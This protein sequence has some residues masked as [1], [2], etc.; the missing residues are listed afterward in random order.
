[1]NPKDFENSSAGKCIKTLDGYWAFLPDPL[2]PL[3][4]YDSKLIKLLSE[5]DRLLGELSGTGRL[6]PNPYL[7]IAPYIRREAVSSSRIEGTQ[8]SLSD[9]FFY[10]AAEWEEPKVPDV[11]EVR[12]YV[13]AMEYGIKRL[14]ELPVSVRLIS[15]IHKI[16]MKG[17]RGEHATPGEIRHSQNWIGPFGCLLNEATYVPPPVEEMNKALSAWEKFIHSNPDEP[18]LIQCALTHYQFEAIHPFLDGNGR[19][20]RLIITFFLCEKG[21]LTQPLLYLSAFFDKYREEYYGRLLAVSQKGDWRGWIEFFLRGVINQSKDAISDAKKILG[22][23]A[24]YQSILEKTKRVPESAHRLIDELFI[25]PVISI[26]GLS[27]RWGMPFNSVKTGVLRLVNTGILGEVTER[28]RN[29]L[30]IAPRLIKL[31]TAT[32][33][34]K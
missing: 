17:V 4:N 2:P 3:I 1:M 29:K 33:G 24:E 25:N 5:A 28:K 22:L 15:E 23:H 34:E 11:M 8:A 12:N 14:M 6:L 19:I 9:L 10:E 30:F 32:D 21:Y 31:L 26:S 18:P 16:L 7:L 27:K 13:Q 20:G